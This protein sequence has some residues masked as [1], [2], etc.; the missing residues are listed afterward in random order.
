MD[1]KND[2]EIL[3]SVNQERLFSRFIN[4]AL[5]DRYDTTATFLS[6]LFWPFASVLLACI[7]YADV[8]NFVAQLSKNL[9]KTSKLK[10]GEL[11]IYISP[12]LLG[13][14]DVEAYKKISEL[15]REEVLFILERGEAPLEVPVSYLKPEDINQIKTLIEKG[16]V[17]PSSLPNP[18]SDLNSE[19]E[20]KLT[21]F[22]MR[23]HR[24]LQSIIIN[25]SQNIL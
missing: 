25:F 3:G 7:F 15:S 5:I 11:E 23:I 20:I 12:E 13:G 16:I 22:G 8:S 21:D 6:K 9:S 24:E 17:T 14:S 10:I 19:I 2:K 18:N 4:S 1:D